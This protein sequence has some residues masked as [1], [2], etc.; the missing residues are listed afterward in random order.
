MLGNLIE[1]CD[2][3]VQLFGADAEQNALKE[4]V[5]QWLTQACH[6]ASKPS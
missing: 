6:T 4:A 2:A 5:R 1:A 3:Y